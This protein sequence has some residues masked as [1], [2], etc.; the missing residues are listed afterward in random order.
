M[1]DANLTELVCVLD[2]SGSMHSIIDDAIGGIN[3][4]I[5]EQQ[6][7]TDGE[8]RMTIVLFDT[9]FDTVQE[10]T[11]IKDV[12]LFTRKTYKPRGSTALLDAVGSTIDSLGERLS[13]LPEEKRPGKVLFVILTDG[14]ENASHRYS[15]ERVKQMIELQ[16]KEYQWQFIYL[17]ADINAFDHGASF[18]IGTRVSYRGTGQ[19]IGSTYGVVST[20]AK[21]FRSSGATGMSIMDSCVDVSEVGDVSIQKDDRSTT[22]GD[23]SSQK[24]STTNDNVN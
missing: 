12:P 7:S 3:H 2:R 23:V 13:R 11:P 10:S 14:H 15:H 4:L 21:Q 24:T 22:D 19:S 5:K 18:G 17:S 8:A 9:A 6:E 16:Q 20:A 1:T